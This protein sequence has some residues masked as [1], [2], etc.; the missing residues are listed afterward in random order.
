V[1]EL[2]YSSIDG[3]TIM[4]SVESILKY[5]YQN[6]NNLHSYYLNILIKSSFFGINLF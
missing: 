1:T 6:Y 5:L 4:P 2:I 3:Q